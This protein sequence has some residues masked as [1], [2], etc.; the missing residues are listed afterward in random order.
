MAAIPFK[1]EN[2]GVDHINVYSRG[3][4]QLGQLLSNFAHT[5]FV[6][7][8]HGAFAS[9]E[10]YWYW[11]STGRSQDHLRRLYGFSAKSAGSKCECVPME[12]SEFRDMI[13]QGTRCKI[14]QSPMLMTALK[15]STLPLAHYY[16]YGGKAVSAEKHRWQIDTLEAIRRELRGEPKCYSLDEI[17]EDGYILTEVSLSSQ[18]S[19]AL[20]N[21][22]AL[23]WGWAT[24]EIMAIRTAP[25]E[26]RVVRDPRGISEA[27][28]AL[29]DDLRTRREEA[30]LLSQALPTD[31]LRPGDL[32]PEDDQHH[33]FMH[34]LL[35]LTGKE[36]EDALGILPIHRQ[37]LDEV[38]QWY[39]RMLAQIEQLPQH[40]TNGYT[41]DLYQELGKIRQQLIHHIRPN[42]QP[43]A[44]FSSPE[45]RVIFYLTQ[46]D[47][48]TRLRGL[49][50]DDVLFVNKSYATAWYEDLVD[51]LKDCTLPDAEDAR[52]GLDQMYEDLVNY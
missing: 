48:T 1:P 33:A 16:E 10:G 5:P 17:Q 52:R 45:A 18:P 23:D 29:A 26:W 8:E 30:L 32:D 36:R 15:E 49:H 24:N 21:Q 43:S 28:A 19:S 31:E 37:N 38:E 13:I 50:V 46:T 20:L 25:K 3:K 47:G 11:C 4:T 40:L 6:H 2:D 9:M 27:H 39:E 44:T 41:C 22:L 51:F 34:N 35:N 7:P 42:R 14:E 12:E